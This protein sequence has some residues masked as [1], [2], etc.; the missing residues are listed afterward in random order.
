MTDVASSLKHA[1]KRHMHGSVIFCASARIT[2]H[3]Q[4]QDTTCM[5]K[6]L[7]RATVGV[8]GIITAWV[9]IGLVLI[10]TP[11]PTF[12][13]KAFT[14]PERG[15]P[16]ACSET[17]NARCF[18]MRDGVVLHGESL[19]SG[20][21]TTVLFLHGVMSDASDL[22][23]AAEALQ[24]ATGATV[25]SLDQRGHGQSAG[26]FGDID[27]VGQYEDDV[28]DVVTALGRT[29]GNGRLILAGHSMG[30]GVAMRYAAKRSLPP[31]DGYLLYAPHLGEEAP[32][33][34]HESIQPAGSV[35]SPVK[36]HLRRTIGLLMLKS[37]G[38]SAF[39]GLGTLYFNVVQ[40]NNLM[41]YSFRAM[42]SCAPDDY[43]VALT[44]DD[45]PLLI[46]AGS[47]D[48]AFKASEYPGAAQLHKAGEA[49][50]VPG[51]THDGILTD[52]I[53]LSAITKWMH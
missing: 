39:D 8:V 51:Q 2:L 24:K 42:I 19:G 7:K 18:T 16:R 48:E 50:I 4:T 38:I 36:L 53:A 41:H 11:A 43:K 37:V 22:R 12:D 9:A 31:V 40:G 28:A 26:R 23:P 21:D 47:K 27:Y 10:A 30:G 13:S 25:I 49:V 17:S 34:S 20:S 46:V 44:A 32:T 6:W 29:I 52:G 1:A 15:P 3:L 5:K 45:K 35:E 33:T 14:I